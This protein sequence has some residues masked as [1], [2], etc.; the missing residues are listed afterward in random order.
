MFSPATDSP[1]RSATWA[2]ER[3]PQ[4]CIHHFSANASRRKRSP[5][6][7]FEQGDKLHFIRLK[8]TSE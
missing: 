3:S 8:K 4:V 5:I 6:E 1:D 7:A 2:S